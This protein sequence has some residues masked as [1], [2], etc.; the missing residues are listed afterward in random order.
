M[1]GIG[2]QESCKS[3]EESTLDAYRISDALARSLGIFSK[4]EIISRSRNR[5]YV[6]PDR[7]R[8]KEEH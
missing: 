8:A 7:D 6:G 3:S 4:M 2:R 5:Q 1:I